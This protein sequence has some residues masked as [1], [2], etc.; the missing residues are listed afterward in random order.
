MF[1]STQQTQLKVSLSQKLDELLHYKAT[2]LGIP[3]T[4]F[5]KYIIIKEIEKE[6]VPVFIASDKIQKQAQKALQKIDKALVV[7]NVPDFFAKL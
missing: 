1:M 3:K 5:V 7:D 4:Q 6:S 2:Q